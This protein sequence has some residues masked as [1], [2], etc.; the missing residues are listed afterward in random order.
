VSSFSSSSGGNTSGIPIILYKSGAAFL[1]NH[2]LL[3]RQAVKTVTI[4]DDDR[5]ECLLHFP[6]LFATGLCP[7]WCHIA[8]S[9]CVSRNNHHSFKHRC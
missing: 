7:F 5:G 1:V 9:E 8:A 3:Q 4:C 2:I 6:C